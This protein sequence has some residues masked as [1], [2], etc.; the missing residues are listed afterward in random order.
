MDP[1]DDE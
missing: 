1:D